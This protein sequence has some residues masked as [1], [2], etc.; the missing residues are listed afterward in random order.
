M[1]NSLD[2]DQD[3]HS[4]GP[5]LDPNCLQRLSA[6]DKSLNN[7]FPKIL[8]GTHS[9]YQTVWIQIRTDILSVLI[10][11]QNVCKGY[12]KTT[13]VTDSLLAGKKLGN[14]KM[15]V[16]FFHCL[17]NDLCS[18]TFCVEISKIFTIKYSTQTLSL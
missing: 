13:K 15:N 1:S 8:S 16:N 11:V 12:Q 18:L 10:W 14:E 9:V 17:I 4:V 2:P 6:D 3:K 5:D 7:F